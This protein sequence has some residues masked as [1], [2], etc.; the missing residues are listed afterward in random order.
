[1]GLAQLLHVGGRVALQS[2]RLARALEDAVELR[3]Q[4]VPRPRRVSVDRQRSMSRA[5]MSS[6]RRSP[7]TGLN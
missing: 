6:M 3:E 5:V 2:V 7:N 4:L 1:V